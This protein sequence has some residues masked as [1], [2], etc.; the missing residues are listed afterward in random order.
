MQLLQPEVK[1][2]QRRYKGDSMKARIAQLELFK[3][4]GISLHMV[5]LSG[6]VTGNGISKL[7]CIQRRCENIL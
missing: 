2:I 7:G 5:D 3:E 1:E 4:R 6:D